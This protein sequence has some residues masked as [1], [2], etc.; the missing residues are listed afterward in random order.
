M[1]RRNS[2]QPEIFRV[3]EG[4]TDETIELGS[5]T[6]KTIHFAPGSTEV[7]L[8]QHIFGFPL[9]NVIALQS[10]DGGPVYEADLKK[11]GFG[12]IPAGTKLEAHPDK[13]VHT[14]FITVSDQYLRTIAKETVRPEKIDLRFLS[15][16]ED[17]AA[18]SAGAL[19]HQIVRDGSGDFT[20]LVDHAVNFLSAR[21]LRV[22]GEDPMAGDAPYPNGLPPA[23]L[24]RVMDYI[25]AHYGEEITLGELAGVAAL[26]PFHFARAFKKTTGVPPVRFLWKRRVDAARQMML[27][28]TDM[29]L[30]SIALAC[31]FKSQSHFTEV[32][33][34]ETATTPAAYRI[35][36]GV[37]RAVLWLASGT[38]LAWWLEA[39]CD[40][41]ALG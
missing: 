31:G 17:A 1:H 40:A 5:V 15:A 34:R 25:D 16:S 21:L 24:R 22:L 19:I 12:F 41:L 8:R 14:L 6:S 30:L 32:F 28:H 27:R 29:T 36:N 37:R 13:P 39:F 33:K 2:F 18:A 23:R 10:I 38:G 3:S 7:R 9:E 20:E 4:T 11:G 35:A 26:S